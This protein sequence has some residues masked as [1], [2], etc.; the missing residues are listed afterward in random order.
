MWRS[1]RNWACLAAFTLLAGCAASQY[2][3]H[4]V[5][6]GSEAPAFSLHQDAESVP[7]VQAI[8]P[9]DVLD[10]IFHIEMAS[11]EAYR[12]QAGDELEFKFPSA[13]EFNGRHLVL[14]DGTV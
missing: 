1:T 7:I 3:E 4:S 14:P 11:A 8:R 6:V 12:I 10:V 13:P 9:H 2:Q 5:P